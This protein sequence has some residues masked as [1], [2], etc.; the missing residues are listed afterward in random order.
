VHSIARALKTWAAD[1][2]DVVVCGGGVRNPHLMTELAAQ[3]CV[4][5][6][7][8][9]QLGLPEQH[10]EALAFAWLAWANCHNIPADLACVTG[11][12]HPRVLGCRY[13]A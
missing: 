2:Q 12:R 13:P 4:P 11:A 7:P 8:S 5:L 1:V 10:V 9:S 3:L 6:I